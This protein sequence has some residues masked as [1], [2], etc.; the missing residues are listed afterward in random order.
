MKEKKKIRAVAYPRYSSDNQREE[1]IVAQ[2]KAIA[3]YCKNKGYALVGN[4]PD[5]A[6]TATTDRRPN[7]QKMIKDSDRGL[8]D[9]V[10]VHKLDRFARDR[11]DSAHYKRS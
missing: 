6:K 1:S 3:E 8:F 2:M 4:Y 11:Y 5:E 7:F 10:V 9:V